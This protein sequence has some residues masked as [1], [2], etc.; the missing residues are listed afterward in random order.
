MPRSPFLELLSSADRAVAVVG[1]RY[2]AT[3]DAQLQLLAD[4]EE[5]QA[6]GCHRDQLS[7]LRV[8]TLARLPM[9][10]DEATE[11]THLDALIARERFGH[12]LEHGIHHHFRISS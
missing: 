10:D 1:V 12:A 8:A 6:F 7:G 4:L 3:V 11:A 9:F 2:G 5:G